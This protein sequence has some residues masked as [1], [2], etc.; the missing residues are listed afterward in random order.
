MSILKKPL[1]TEKSTKLSEKLN[2]FAFKVTKNATKEQIKS[3]IELVYEVAVASVNTMIYVGK[4]KSKYTKK[5]FV[6]GK[7]S[8]FKKAI[9]TLKDGHTIDYFGAD[10]NTQTN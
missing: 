7:K 3:E 9:V 4:S 5:G 1:I 8:D 2:K 6:N 10:N